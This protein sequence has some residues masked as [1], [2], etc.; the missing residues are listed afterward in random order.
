[1]SVPAL[2]RPWAEELEGLDPEL[3]SVLGEP[4]R[5]LT[6]MVGAPS[7]PRPGPTGE[8][9][10]FDGLTRRG[11]LDRLLLSEWALAEA[12]PLE[13]LR[14]ATQ[15]EQSFLQLR[16]L[17][18]ASSRRCVVLLDAPPSQHGEARLMHLVALVVLAARARRGG[19][20]MS[21]GLLQEGRLHPDLSVEDHA[22]ADYFAYHILNCRG[23]S[24][25]GGTDE[26]QRNTLGERALGL[27]REPGP[28]RNTPF[29]ELLKN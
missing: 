1:M 27:P 12:A 13:F 28:D 19:L 24:L 29:R 21:W 11:P 8:P 4:L 14:R 2:L 23:M 3:V 7:A 16:R 20:A 5:Q 18:P 10:G 22:D 6:R 26:I 9:D 17:D 25:G 15:A